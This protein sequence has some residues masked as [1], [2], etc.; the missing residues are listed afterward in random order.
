VA[1]HDRPVRLADVVKLL[2][3]AKEL[4]L[5]SE[6]KLFNALGVRQGCVTPFGLINDCAEEKLVS[7]V[8]VDAALLDPGRYAAV[9][10]HPLVNTAT[11]T[12]AT[13][14]FLRFLSLTGHVVV[15]F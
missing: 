8:L 15:E 9:S 13:G 3:G 11:T 10:F 12:V 14:D 5:A 1:Q 4:R 2:P 6:D 7:A